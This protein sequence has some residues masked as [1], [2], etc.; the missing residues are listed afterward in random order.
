M[1]LSLSV[2]FSPPW[3]VRIRTTFLFFLQSTWYFHICWACGRIRNRVQAHGKGIF[4]R[5]K[6]WENWSRTESITWT[7]QVKSIARLHS[8]MTIHMLLGGQVF[9]GAVKKCIFIFLFYLS[10]HF[11]K[12]LLSVSWETSKFLEESMY[13][14]FFNPTRSLAISR[15]LT[16]SSI[17]IWK[18]SPEKF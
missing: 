5:L 11:L 16:L 9:F 10:L 12:F 14:C 18:I 17:E 2:S 8:W 15:F 6:D 3:N 13:T 7:P 4:V 1:P